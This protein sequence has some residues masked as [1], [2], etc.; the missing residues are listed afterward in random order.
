M[1][2][3]EKRERDV[4]KFILP[5]GVFVYPKLHKPDTRWKPEGQYEVK[6]VIDPKG[7]FLI[8][9]GKD[10]AT[11]EEIYE[12]LEGLL[13]RKL[14]AE[15]ARLSAIAKGNDAKKAKKAKATLEALK[16]R[17]VQFKA[18]EDDDGNETDKLE[19]KA[20]MRA[21]GERDD[22]TKWERKP[23]VFDAAG[24]PLKKVP[25]VFGGSEGKVAVEAEGYYAPPKQDEPAVV[26]VTLRLDGVQILK[27]VKGG[28][29]SASSYGFGREEGY[30]DEGGS[31]ADDTSDEDDDDDKSDDS[32]GGAG[33]DDDDF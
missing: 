13:E 29:R 27:L 23:N 33:D 15:K 24:N 19:V 4:F 7:T 10:K 2:K 16:K 32:A 22:G 5:R 26:G 6:S 9:N 14:K 20:T 11:L 28:E 12:A 25:V 18:H 8:N 30:E 31:D 1:A 21:S 3:K 17:D